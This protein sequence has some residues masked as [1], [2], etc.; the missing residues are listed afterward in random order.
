[1]LQSPRRRKLDYSPNDDV[2]L[3]RHQ[4]HTEGVEQEDPMRQN[5]VS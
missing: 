5:G 4:P 2:I 3:V 1:M